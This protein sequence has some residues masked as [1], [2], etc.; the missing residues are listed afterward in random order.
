[1]AS[2]YHINFSGIVQGV[3][4]RPWLHSL[5]ETYHLSGW[6]RNTS[7]GVEL[8]AQGDSAQTMQFLSCL[9]TDPPPLAYILDL[10]IQAIALETN[11]KP[12]LEIKPSQ[13]NS[14]RTLVSPDVAMCH[15]CA[16][17]QQDSTNRRFNYEF[18]NCTHCGPR[19]T[20]IKGLPYDRPQTTMADFPMCPACQAEYLDPHDRRFHAQPIA[21]S[22]CGPH[23]LW[24]GKKDSDWLTKAVDSLN[25][26]QTIALQGLGGYHL[27]CR[28]DS[29][30]AL[31]LLRQ[32]KHRPTK[33]FAV[34]VK[35]PAVARNW[36]AINPTELQLLNSKQAPI[37]LLKKKADY[38]LPQELAPA[39]GYL[40]VMLPYTP[41]H[42][43]LTA[44]FDVPLVMTSG[45]HSGEPLCIHHQEAKQVLSAYVDHFLE[46]N[47][48]I[49][50]RCDDSVWFVSNKQPQPIR[51]SRGY[52]PLPILLPYSLVK[53]MVAAGA[54][55]K[56]VPAVAVGNL[57]FLT[58]HIGDLSSYK[59]QQLQQT[60]LTDFEHLFKITPEVIVADKHPSYWSSRYARE[61]SVH[62]KLQLIE[63]Q[64]HHAHLAACLA[65]NKFFGQAIGIC[66][67]GTGYGDDGKIWGGEAGVVNYQRFDRKFHLDY[68][69]LPGGDSG[70]KH[71]DRIAAAY[72]YVLTG[73]TN[74]QL[75]KKMIDQKLNCPETS[76]MGRLF[77][78]VSATL[79]LCTTV[80]HEAE[81]AM[82]LEAAAL[83]STTSKSYPLNLSELWISLNQDRSSVYEKA[84]KFH[85][86]IA[87][88]TLNWAEQISQASGLTN[89][90]L[91]GGVWQ[92]R[93][94]L[95][96]T[97]PKLQ[98]HGFTVLTHHQLPAN[99]AGIAYGQIAVAAALLNR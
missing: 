78:A 13:D 54:D 15:K 61:R 4:F 75:I 85:N 95:S 98:Q 58:Q 81:A 28:A 65:E 21:C 73:K 47:R 92:N 77:D 6:V 24:D 93:L 17:E 30:S 31:T 64:H 12:G 68:L 55:L 16:A 51:R 56:N 9:R 39:N 70:T 23:M 87:E 63:V 97:I 62:H 25:Q 3:G 34:M 36:V 38:S 10:Q 57:V 88:M 45:N 29:S 53:P 46:H 69:P 60:T 74:N 71:P 50:R 96:L 20:I 35:S 99:D 11:S 43:L 80:T 72:S 22:T 90:A 41:I 59:T 40:G 76:S 52:T 84:R 7:A 49:H 83:N 26:H 82:A 14:G 89:V 67:D 18:I 94:L 33:P 27:V 42:S 66:F 19:F 1:M 79:T 32:R 2:R 86:T 48:P 8:E 37:V 5:A 44:A 91:S